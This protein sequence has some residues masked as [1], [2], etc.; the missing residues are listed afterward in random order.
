MTIRKAIAAVLTSYWEFI[1]KHP[2]LSMVL[3]LIMAA[4]CAAG[5][6]LIFRQF[7][8]FLQ[9]PCFRGGCAS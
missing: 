8:T 3:S 5:I 7:P 2:L 9:L 1:Q 4:A 6:Y